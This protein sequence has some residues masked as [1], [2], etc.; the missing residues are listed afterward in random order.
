MVD[1]QTLTYPNIIATKIA[2]FPCNPVSR[3]P[4]DKAERKEYEEE[5]ATSTNIPF[6]Q[7]YTQF[8]FQIVTI[9]RTIYLLNLRRTSQKISKEQKKVEKI[10]EIREKSEKKLMK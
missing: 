7:K 3:N 1:L 4:V 5:W 6:R 8:F 2:D 10:Q 9:E